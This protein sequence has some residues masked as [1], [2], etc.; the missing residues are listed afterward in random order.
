MFR[1]GRVVGQHD[2]AGHGGTTQF[3]RTPSSHVASGGDMA[4]AP[5]D[6]KGKAL[7]DP[8]RYGSKTAD[9]VSVYGS[10][11]PERS[12]VAFAADGRLAQPSHFEL[13][14]GPGGVKNAVLTPKVCTTKSC[15]SGRKHDVCGPDSRRR[16]G[17]QFQLQGLQDHLLFR[18]RFRVPGQDE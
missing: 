4:R 9:V 8:V 1:T 5:G 13:S 7:R 15:R 16:L 3:H 18:L 6:D 11:V 10:C 14:N 12:G 17:G 2:R